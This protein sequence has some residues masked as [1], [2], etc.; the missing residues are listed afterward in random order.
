MRHLKNYRNFSDTTDVFG[1]NLHYRITDFGGG[2]DGLVR[3]I[4][5]GYNAS[6]QIKSVTSYNNA[7][8]GN[9]ST[10]NEVKYE[11]GETGCYRRNT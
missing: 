10:L 11:Y 7:T 4:S 2:V 6:G 8:V 1:M 3:R 9:G 5:I